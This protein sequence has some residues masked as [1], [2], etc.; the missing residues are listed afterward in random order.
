MSTPLLA[1]FILFVFFVLLR[2]AWNRYR[3]RGASTGVPS[4]FDLLPANVAGIESI[5][6]DGRWWYF[7]FADDFVMSP[8]MDDIDAMAAYAAR[9]LR[10]VEGAID[11]SAWRAL[12]EESRAESHLASLERRVIDL[13]GLKAAPARLR[14]APGPV[15]ELVQATHLH[16]LLMSNTGDQDFPDPPPHVR[17]AFV[18]L[19]L[20]LDDPSGSFELGLEILGGTRSLP[21]GASL[22]DAASGVLWLWDALI[23]LQGWDWAVTLGLRPAR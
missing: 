9:H 11:A 2:A 21:E 4:L 7:G 22:Q 19:G 6:L 5:Q 10:Q 17:D 20:E 8:L 12:A 15:P 1:A 13:A 23:E 14:A 3:V 18:R 16:Y